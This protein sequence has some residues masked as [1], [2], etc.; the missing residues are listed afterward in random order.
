MAL[1]SSHQ[2]QYHQG[3]PT[4]QRQFRCSGNKCVQDIHRTQFLA[5]GKQCPLGEEKESLWLEHN[6]TLHIWVHSRC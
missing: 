6:N 5:K 1:V 2:F 3:D 4:E